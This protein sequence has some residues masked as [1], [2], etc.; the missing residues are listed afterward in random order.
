MYKKTLDYRGFEIKVRDD[1]SL[2]GHKKFVYM[3]CFQRHDGYI[4]E[5]EEDFVY[6]TELED[7]VKSCK[8]KVDRIIKIY[9][10]CC[11]YQCTDLVPDNTP[12]CACD[13]GPIYEDC[14]EVCPKAGFCDVAKHPERYPNPRKSEV[15]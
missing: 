4:Y 7:V 6:I 10:E 15:K 5:L 8:F 2:G 13:T 9:E 1:T 3:I 11:C 14:C 12:D